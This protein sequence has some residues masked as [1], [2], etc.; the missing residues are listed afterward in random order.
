MMEG[1]FLFATGC[2][3]EPRVHDLIRPVEAHE[4]ERVFV[5]PLC[6]SVIQPP[7][8]CYF[9]TLRQAAPIP[10]CRLC[11]AICK[12]LRPIPDWVLD[13]INGIPLA[14]APPTTRGQGVGFY[15]QS[16]DHHECKPHG[17]VEPGFPGR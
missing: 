6:G 4:L 11:G 2:S 9:E 15:A 8:N 3:H 10:R 13:S 5:P 17:A 16:K 1:P 7:W 14:L 12:Q